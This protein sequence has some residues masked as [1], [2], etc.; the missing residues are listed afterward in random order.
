MNTM[1]VGVWDADWN[2]EPSFEQDGAV[3]R[4]II[5]GREVAKIEKVEGG[6]YRY[7]SAF[8]YLFRQERQDCIVAGLQR[9]GF[10]VYVEGE[11]NV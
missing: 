7:S 1:T 5:D 6:L 2:A 8:G 11:P 9:D 10:T 4:V 3:E